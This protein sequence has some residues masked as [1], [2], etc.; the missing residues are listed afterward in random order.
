MKNDIKN[1]L[2]TLLN[3]YQ[4]H[5]QTGMTTAMLEGVKDFEQVNIIL[6]NDRHVREMQKIY[7]QANFL[8]VNNLDVLRGRKGPILVDHWVVQNLLGEC[9][10][11]IEKLE[12]IVAGFLYERISTIR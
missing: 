11:E 7:P 1:K 10:E 8:T 12:N 6:E 5:R 9:L 4:L 3:L 2:Y